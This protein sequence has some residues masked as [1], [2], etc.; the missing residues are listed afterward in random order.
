MADEPEKD[1]YGCCVD[2][3][4]YSDPELV[5]SRCRLKPP[6]VLPAG[7]TAWPIV[8]AMD[9]CGQHV[10]WRNSAEEKPE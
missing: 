2:C 9:W 3:L 8:Q 10:R 6:V 4:Y 7:D 5:Q 1:P